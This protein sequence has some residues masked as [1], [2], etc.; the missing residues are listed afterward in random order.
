MK[1]PDFK[2]EQWMNEH[3][4]DAVYNLT[5][6]CS[7]ALTLQE[8]LDLTTMD[9]QS[10]VLDYG[11]ITGNIQTKKAILQLYQKGTVDEI[12]TC[13]G[14]L[15]GNELVMNTLLEPDDHVITFVPGYQ[16]F[17]DIPKS[18]G[19]AV[20]TIA[21]KENQNWTCSIEDV[22]PEIQDR[23]KMI[24]INNPN[25]PTGTYFDDDFLYA[26]C[27]VCKEKKIYILCDEVYRGFH[28]ETSISDIYEYGISTSSLSKVFAL[29]GLR[30]GWIKAN[31]EIIHKINVRRDY[32]M[33]STGPFIDALAFTALDHA[34]DLMDRNKQRILHNQAII[35]NWLKK[36]NRFHVYLPKTGTVSFMK[37]DFDMPSAEFAE[38]LLKETGIFFVP[39]SCFDCEYH[40]RLGLGQDPM[41][42]E[43]GLQLL[44]QWVDLKFDS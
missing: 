8:L 31:T 42:M 17:I 36:E 41:Q 33:I 16:Q 7:K 1:L 22:L 21:L 14:C 35:Q 10:L 2:V 23:T 38:K 34:E 24:I 5:D 20:T 6:T 9:L 18:L 15:A 29:A 12:T 4:M 30:F 40:V 19:C 11:Q 3:E 32:T 39:G 13:H 26:L 44:S 43:K 27:N 37:Y 28:H 25:N